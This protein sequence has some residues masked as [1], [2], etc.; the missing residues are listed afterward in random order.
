[1]LI[2]RVYTLTK[3]ALKAYITL[4]KAISAA[5]KNNIIMRYFNAKVGQPK[6]HEFLVKTV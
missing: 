4:N 5:H 2:I 1:M 6:R 3:A